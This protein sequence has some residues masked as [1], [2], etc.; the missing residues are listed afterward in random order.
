M[1][2]ARIA[3]IALSLIV[4]TP[5]W[6]AEVVRP[7]DVGEPVV[8]G[9]ASKVTRVGRL[10]L[11]DQ[12]DEVG[13]QQA[14]EHDVSVVINLREPGELSWDERT[15]V[16]SLGMT[17]YNVPIAKE[18]PLSSAPM[19]EIEKIVQRSGSQQVLIHCATA[20]RAA[21]WLVT[22][23]TRENGMSTDDALLVAR[24]AGLTKAES[25]AKVRAFLRSTAGATVP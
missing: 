24:R 14:R 7:E 18:G 2:L 23:L 11:A 17:Y 22:H 12:P 25:E 9:S 16:E 6:S 21:A 13:L 1:S 19:L 4:A 10:W 8:W 15:A 20:N 5:V 3:A